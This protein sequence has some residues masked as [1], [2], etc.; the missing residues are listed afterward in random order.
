MS[1][2][3][4]LVVGE[5]LIDFIPSSRGDLRTVESFSR[6]PGGAPANVAVRLAALDHTPW[7]WTRIS[8]DAFGEYLH[9][10]LSQAG[11]P[12]RFVTRDDEAATT[13]AFVGH[14]ADAD[15]SFK[16]YRDGT[17]DTRL[18]AGTV[19]NDDLAGVECVYVGGVIL[20]SGRSRDAVIDLIERA[21]AHECT[22]YLDPNFRPELWNPTEFEAVL[23][24]VIE[25]VD[26][27][28]ATAEE[29]DRCGF[30][31]DT[32]RTI[33]E[34]VCER[35]PHAVLMTLGRDGAFAYC[36][37]GSFWGETRLE[38]PAFDV[39]VADTTGA[40]DAFVAGTLYGI[41]NEMTIEETLNTANTMAALSITVEGAM[42]DLPSRDKVK[43]FL[44]KNSQFK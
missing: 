3:N 17:A 36:D 31:G 41:L 35:G 21:S 1:E 10:T 32:K 28:K 4:V 8:T 16:F 39:E 43:Q 29:L 14:D 33:C 7:F 5:T 22:V 2:A 40:G 11:I 25:N 6:R 42:N 15:R 24:A 38:R 27:V 37:E 13:L 18:E 20:A 9:K 44:N 12:N 19:S 34:A 26:V 30:G 23:D